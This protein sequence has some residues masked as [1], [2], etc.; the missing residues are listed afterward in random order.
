MDTVF[1]IHFHNIIKR[2]GL[3]MEKEKTPLP[4]G[5]DV[6]INISC[7]NNENNEENTKCQNTEEL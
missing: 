3:I 5:L 1:Y 4:E 2:G 7:N 6:I